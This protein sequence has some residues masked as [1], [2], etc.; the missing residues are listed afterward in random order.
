MKFYLLTIWLFY[1]I[2]I[3]LNRYMLQ[4]S[5]S[6]TD[7]K[8]P[9][10]IYSINLNLQYLVFYKSQNTVLGSPFQHF[11][12]SFFFFFKILQIIKSV[13]IFLLMC[14]YILFIPLIYVS[15]TSF[16]T[17][18][19]QDHNVNQYS[20]LLLI[21]LSCLNKRLFLLI[22]SLLFKYLGVQTL[23]NPQNIFPTFPNMFKHLIYLIRLE[24]SV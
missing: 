20:T 9:L 19:I 10:V 3:P 6:L 15:Y 13:Y 4:W 2:I 14:E 23:F 5:L 17:R 22:S 21:V 8:C 24:D 18:F 16:C 12:F 11:N 1:L 7:K